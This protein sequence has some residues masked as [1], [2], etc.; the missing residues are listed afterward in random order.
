VLER[1]LGVAPDPATRKAFHRLMAQAHPAARSP[2]AA[3][4]RAGR[5]GLPTAPLVGRSAELSALYGVW[6]AAVAGR[7]GLVLVRGGAGVGKTAWW[8]SWPRWHGCRHR[9][10]PDNLFHINQNIQPASELIA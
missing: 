3:N 1:E 7:G 8:R 6:R 10:D 5:P 2:A 9:Y 4:P